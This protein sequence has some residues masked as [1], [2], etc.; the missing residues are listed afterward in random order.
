MKRQALINA[1]ALAAAATEVLDE[2]R[3][4]LLQLDQGGRVTAANE[5]ARALLNR[6]DGLSDEDGYLRAA[7]PSEDTRLQNLI[8]QA[9]PANGRAGW[10]GSMLVSREEPQPRL[11]LHVCRPN[12]GEEE[13]RGTLLGALVLV[14]D[15]ASWKRIDPERV[16]KALNLTQA[17]SRI[18]VL[19]AQGMS[20]DAV[21]AL[22]VRSRTTI[23]WHMRQIY[24]KHG[25]HRQAEL[26]HLVMS[27]LNV[28]KIRH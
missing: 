2:D 3:V 15:P 27:L 22:L 25:L 11:T 14:E 13:P 20:I 24:A 16:R 28:P 4:G 19:L 7:V 5:V 6:R 1:R 8:A 12:E 21:A 10:G 18:A 9:L 26:A 23:K 17:E